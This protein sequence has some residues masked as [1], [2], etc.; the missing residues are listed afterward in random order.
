MK[1]KTVILATLLLIISMVH[2]Q[3]NQDGQPP[4]PPTIEDHL[5]HV[6][7]ALNKQLELS[8]AQK[9]KVLAA[10]KTFFADIEKNRKKDGKLPPPPPP[11]PVSKEI[12]DKLSAER[13]AKIKTVLS[14]GQYKKYVEIEKKMRP[15]HP[16]K[17][18]E[19]G[20]EKP[21]TEE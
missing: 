17:P 5:K 3:P 16:G 11:P 8:A 4:N 14:P 10:Y 1:K 6:S 21:P 18:D 20:P 13:D 2:A 19:R 9:D 15:K 7:E 12:A